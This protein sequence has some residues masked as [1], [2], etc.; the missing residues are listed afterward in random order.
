MSE[1][2]APTFPTFP[3]F[4]PST[5]P[6]SSSQDYRNESDLLR[7]N[8]T[9]KGDALTRF[10]ELAHSIQEDVVR[11]PVY[12]RPPNVSRSVGM[13]PWMIAVWKI[14]VVHT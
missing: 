3:H 12:L 10:Y 11:A 8:K 1:L 4:Q 14:A 13:L 2:K 7:R 5:L 9:A 6:H